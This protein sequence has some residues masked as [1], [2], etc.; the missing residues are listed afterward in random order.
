MAYTVNKTNPLALPSTYTVQDAVLNTETDLSLVGKGYAGYGEVIAENFVHL[1]E[2]FSGTS[3]PSKP[4]KGQLWYDE[5][6][7][8]IKVYSGTTFNQIS[9]ATYQSA[10]PS[11]PQTGDLWADSDTNQLYFYTGS[12]FQ[13]VGPESSSGSG[14]TFETVIDNSDVSRPVTKIQN[15]GITVAYISD[16][17][18]FTPKTPISGFGSIAGAGGDIGTG[19]TLNTNLSTVK[20]HGTAARAE[21]LLD[22][23]DVISAANVLRADAADTTTGQLTIDTDTG[24]RIGDAQD[25]VIDVESNNIFHS[26]DIQDK[27]IIFRVNYAGTAN[28]ELLRLD[29]STKRIGILN[30]SPTT[31]LDVTGTV[32]ATG[33]SGP[34]TGAVTGNVSGTAS[35]ASTVTIAAKDSENTTVFPTF[36]ASATGNNALFTD[37]GLSYNPSTNVLNTTATQAQYADL[38]EM[39]TSDGSYEPGNV[40]IFGGDKEVTISKFA[41]DTRVAGVVSTKPAYLMNADSEGVAVALVGKVP[42]RV[43]GMIQKG[44]LLTTS[45]EHQGCAKKSLDPKTGT[46]IGKALENYSSTDV[47]T[48]FI[49]VGMQ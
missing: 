17:D 43:H 1:L 46:I 26:N 27:D 30:S 28:T 29:G 44:D 39:Y 2:N 47:G 18:L 7:N 15:D 34:L 11:N 33:F 37:T 41:Q 5:G 42:C 9:G 12:A 24:I 38:A 4:I 31:E 32:T 36:S 25:Y 22:G 40:L 20:L 19:I 10:E 8:K 21:N 23:S 3:Q 48:I 6:T 13:L 14:F 49:S 35:V 45:G 16:N